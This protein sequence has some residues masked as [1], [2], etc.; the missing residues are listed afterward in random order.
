[1][2]RIAKRKTENTITDVFLIVNLLMNPLGLNTY[3]YLNRAN[4]SVSHT[5]KVWKICGEVSKKNSKRKHVRGVQ[6]IEKNSSEEYER[7][8]LQEKPFGMEMYEET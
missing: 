5:D 1:M 2:W 7:M 6:V 8:Y 4:T 3:K